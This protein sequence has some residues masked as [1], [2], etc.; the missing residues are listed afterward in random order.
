[1]YDPEKGTL[2][3]ESQQ[4]FASDE[5]GYYAFISA[6][7]SSSGSVGIG[8]APVV[9]TVAEPNVI[10]GPN[11]YYGVL[12]LNQAQEPTGFYDV[13]YKCAAQLDTESSAPASVAAPRV[14]ALDTKVS[15]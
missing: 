3:M 6:T 5:E 12:I 4:V 9:F 13:Y 7:V 2:T 11:Y 14:Y 10:T 8:T 15:R 1:M